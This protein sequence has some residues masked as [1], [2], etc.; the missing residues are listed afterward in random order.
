MEKT[1]NIKQVLVGVQSAVNTLNDNMAQAEQK[2]H[3]EKVST[4]LQ[5]L[6]PHSYAERKDR[7]SRKIDGTCRWFTEHS[8]FN[9]W[10]N[11][12]AANTLWVSADPGC[13]KSVL[14][15]YLIDEVLSKENCTICYFFFKDDF[16]DQKTACNAVRAMIHQLVSTQRTV[17]TES[18]LAMFDACGNKIVDSFTRLWS[19][20]LELSK[21]FDTHVISVFDALDECQDGDRS[22][23]IKAICE[24]SSQENHIKIMVLSRP[25]FNIQNEFARTKAEIPVLHLSGESDDEQELISKEIDFVIRHRI[26]VFCAHRQL[27]ETDHDFLIKKLISVP[28][29]TYLWVHLTLTIIEDAPGFTR[30]DTRVICENLPPS[31]NAAYERILERSVDRRRTRLLLELILVAKRPLKVDE[32]CL[33]L[34]LNGSQAD[35]KQ[36][37]EFLEPEDR[38]KQ[39]V[40]SLCGLFVVI[41]DGRLYLLHQTAREFLIKNKLTNTTRVTSNVI[42][43]LTSIN[44]VQETSWN[45]SFSLFKSNRA[46][47]ECCVWLFRLCS[48]QIV[49]TSLYNYCAI[50]W[51]DHF[52]QSNC[53]FEDEFLDLVY[54][55]CLT[56]RE[57]GKSWLD[58][59]FAR[60]LLSKQSWPDK[61][62]VWGNLVTDPHT[63]TL[64]IACF[65]GLTSLVERHFRGTWKQNWDQDTMSKAL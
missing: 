51:T 22:M 3:N 38:F 32:A 14:A 7:N 59:F 13:G 50:Y 24:N 46:M 34:V 16:P 52:K 56:N 37:E 25:Y 29:K 6:Y 27:S 39:T 35:H 19:M 40:R 8:L 53:E 55:Y 47:T 30:G 57:H 49:Y 33:L 26:H 61:H 10:R 28:Q 43:P 63:S 21:N 58:V 45:Q 17:M 23:L 20:F 60:L 11:G 15:K 65:F 44:E 9:Q 4:F 36:L 12:H 54:R 48:D 31:V 64:I 1:E 2:A 41:V 62:L 5:I 18:I 42:A